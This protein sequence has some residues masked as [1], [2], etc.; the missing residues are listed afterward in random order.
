V[1]SCGPTPT[2]GFGLLAQPSRGSGPCAVMA[3]HD[4]WSSLGGAARQR[5]PSRRGLHHPDRGTAGR[6]SGKVV[7]RGLHHPDRG[8][9]G[10]PAPAQSQRGWPVSRGRLREGRPGIEER[11]STT[12]LGWLNLI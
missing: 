12:V 11:A 5:P 1:H 10:R 6:W 3:Q 7:R 4:A 9:A 8:T 2:H